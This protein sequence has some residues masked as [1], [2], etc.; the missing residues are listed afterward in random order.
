[1]L[2]VLVG[3]IVAN[4]CVKE[5]LLKSK[6]QNLIYNVDACQKHEWRR[7]NFSNAAQ[8]LSARPHQMIPSSQPKCALYQIPNLRLNQK[9]WNVSDEGYFHLV[10]YNL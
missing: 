6:P 9:D 1:V 4:I 3:K 7:M 10:F 2:T 8:M 5:Q